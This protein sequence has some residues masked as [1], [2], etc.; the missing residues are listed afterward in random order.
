MTESFVGLEGAEERCNDQSGYEGRRRKDRLR[1]FR[2]GWRRGA[3]KKSFEDPST[4][5]SLTWHNL[6][7]RLGWMIGGKKDT[8]ERLE[9]I[10]D[11][12]ALQYRESGRVEWEE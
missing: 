9:A 6:G 3:N 11:Q 12:L 8:D 2:A 1:E 4:L 5:D 7:W 10:F